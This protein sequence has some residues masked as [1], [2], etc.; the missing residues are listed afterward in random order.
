DRA[1]VARGR[2]G[3]AVASRWRHSRARPSAVSTR[4][5]GRGRP[6]RPRG[7]HTVR[8]TGG[9]TRRRRRAS[10]TP[11]RGHSSD[12]RGAGSGRAAAGR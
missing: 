12:T 4:A 9:Q 11:R 2:R 3:T 7:C 5:P 10:T 8:A 1:G 6:G